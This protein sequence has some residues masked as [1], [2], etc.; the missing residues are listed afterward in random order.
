[1]VTWEFEAK[2]SQASPIKPSCN[3]LH[4]KVST[5]DNKNR[6]DLKKN[7]DIDTYTQILETVRKGFDCSWQDFWT[8]SLTCEKD[9]NNDLGNFHELRIYFQEIESRHERHFLLE[10][11][12]LRAKSKS[13][14]QTVFTEE[15]GV[16]GALALISHV[17]DLTQADWNVI[18]EPNEK[19]KFLD[20]RKKISHLASNSEKII[21]VEAKGT[22]V[23]KENKGKKHKKNIKRHVDSIRE[24]KAEQRPLNPQNIFFGVV[25]S[26]STE[27]DIPPQCLIIDPP[28]MFSSAVPPEKLRLLSRLNFYLDYLN[29]I[30]RANYLVAL[31]TR[32]SAITALNNYLELDTQSLKNRNGEDFRISKSY[33]TALTS[34]RYENDRNGFGEV[35]PFN[36]GQGSNYAFFFFGMDLNIPRKMIAQ[37]FSEINSYR[38][39]FPPF[40]QI[41]LEARIPV[42]DLESF[43]IDYSELD[44]TAN[45]RRAILPL[46]GNL[47]CNSSGL[48]WGQ[49]Q[50]FNG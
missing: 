37:N 42:R 36:T 6:E 33:S 8:Y 44:L 39:D 5:F 48:I 32:I 41:T 7:L 27:P 19:I 46:E 10:E 4:F 24:K 14:R 2:M 15:V 11:N 21:E 28:A 50:V 13:P 31:A 16:G 9:E 17:Y 1:M 20:F 40:F 18:P 23:S 49:L 47:N 3:N 22:F 34:F 35:K 30:S 38:C 43:R 26:Y 29:S 12:V 45:G 25:T